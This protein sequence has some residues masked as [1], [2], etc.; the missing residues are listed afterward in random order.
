MR[1]VLLQ[2]SA[3]TLAASAVLLPL[4]PAAAKNSES[5]IT[6]PQALAV[7]LADPRRD[8]DR[9]RDQYRHPA[10]TLAFCKV[11]PGQTVVDYTP[12]SGWY[13]RILASYLG[14]KGRY[15]G[16]NPDV[17]KG[18]DS[19]KEYY[20]NLGATFPAK[21]ATWTGIPAERIGAYNSDGVPG[22][23]K[24]KVDRVL[25]MREVHNLWRDGIL[26]AELKTIRTLLDDDGLLCI[27]Q[28]RAKAKAPFS[29]TDGGMGYMREKDVIALIEAHGFEFVAKSEINANKKDPAN[30]ADGV[31]MLPPNL[32]NVSD[33]AQRARLIAIGESDR[34]TLLFRKRK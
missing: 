18:S 16:L 9:I 8:A 14:E 6:D 19:M 32:S 1:R 7:T 23:L 4:L 27:E 10:Q 33:E 22:S 17:S 13:T 3:V 26:G 25:L 11:K 29:Y 5:K 28:H 12:S 21:V 34:M 30:H 31:W 2:F 24:E 20:A 15:I